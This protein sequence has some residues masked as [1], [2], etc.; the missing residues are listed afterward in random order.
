MTDLS[1]FGGS[2]W[3]P[4]YLPGGFHSLIFHLQDHLLCV[5]KS[6]LIIAG[7]LKRPERVQLPLRDL[8]SLDR[9]AFPVR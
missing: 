7:M 9:R 1:K 4:G 5:C 8:I 2:G 6:Q 3:I